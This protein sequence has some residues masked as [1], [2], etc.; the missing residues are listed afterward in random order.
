EEALSRKVEELAGW[1]GQAGSE[2]RLRDIAYT[3]QMG[4]SQFNERVAVV[5]ETVEEL[6]EKLGALSRGDL[7]AGVYR[8]RIERVRLGRGPAAKERVAESFEE[9]SEGP[10]RAEHYVNRLE[11]LAHLYV[12]GGEAPWAEL[13]SAEDH[14]R[15]SLPTYPFAKEYYYAPEP[16]QPSL[17]LT[18]QLGQIDK[19]HPLIDRNISTLREERFA[20]RLTGKEFFLTDHVIFEQKILPGAAYLEMAR[21]A[22]AIAG[23]RKVSKLKNVFFAKPIRLDEGSDVVNVSVNLSPNQESLNFE[24]TSSVVE[25][26]DVVNAQGTIVFEGEV[27]AQHVPE[28]IDLESITQRCTQS[29]QGEECYRLFENGGVKY[30]ASFRAIKLLHYGES[31]GLAQLELPPSLSQA[32]SKFVLHPS[33]VDAALQTVIA[34]KGEAEAGSAYLPIAVGEVELLDDL[35]ERC[36]AHVLRTDGA[37]ASA[38]QL[39]KFNILIADEAGQVLIKITDFAVKAF[40]LPIAEAESGARQS[41]MNDT[42]PRTTSVD[43]LNILRE[44]ESGALN[45]DDAERALEEIYA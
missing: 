23:E 41:H 12:R 9:E 22:G 45:A 21:A 39:K 36:Y 3:L 40:R 5:V 13:Y 19:L 42:S 6:V 34:F 27:S 10:V 35:P 14:R 16:Q 17:S 30:G 43:L 25:E 29:L 28:S 1:V 2:A 31:E 24:I 32:F 15:V 18:V 38:S 33:L 44:I 11:R 20:T 26:L 37:K 4:R 8:G 7:V